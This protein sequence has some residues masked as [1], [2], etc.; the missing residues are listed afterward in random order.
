MKDSRVLSTIRGLLEQ[1]DVT[2]LA[3]WRRELAPA[4]LQRLGVRRVALALARAVLGACQ[5]QRSS[6]RSTALSRARAPAP[7]SNLHYA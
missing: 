6:E 2:A 3:K 5:A 1:L 7:A 4:Q